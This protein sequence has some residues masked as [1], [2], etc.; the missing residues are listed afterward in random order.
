[1]L[2]RDLVLRNCRHAG[3]RVGC[4]KWFLVSDVAC[5]ELMGGD[6]AAGEVVWRGEDTGQDRVLILKKC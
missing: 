1:M 5:G 2:T 3:R 6:E 4:E